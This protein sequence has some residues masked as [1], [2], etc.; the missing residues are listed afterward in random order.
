MP[1]R[2]LILGGTT[3]ARDLADRLVGQ[4]YDV[5]TSLAGVTANPVLPQGK[6]VSGGFGGA[7]GL[8]AF[9]ALEGFDLVVDATHPFAVQIAQN[10]VEACKRCGLK[11]VRLERAVWQ[12]HPGDMWFEAADTAEAVARLHSGGRAFVTIGR[13]ELPLFAIRDDISVVARLIEP[14][15]FE[16]PDNWRIVL[17][18]PPFTVRDEVA[19]MR[20]EDV[21]VLVTKNAGGKGRAKLDAARELRLPVIMIR[22]PNKPPAPVLENVELV[23]AVVQED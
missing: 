4:G 2:I 23:M 17:A 14:P 16:R 21:T 19:L 15:A 18:R 12:Q 8:A 10:A 20:T 13:K 6:V 1:K 22:R 11:L 7:D 9:L 3:E 5:T